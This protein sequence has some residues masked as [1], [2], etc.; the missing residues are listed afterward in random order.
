[1]AHKWTRWLHNPCRPGGPHR[2]KAGAESQ[3][4]TSGPGGYIT[5]AAWWVPTTSERGAQSDVANKWAGWLHNP[6]PLAGPQ[7]FRAGD[8]ISRGPQVPL[9]V[10]NMPT[11]STVAARVEQTKS[12]WGRQCL[13]TTNRN[14]RGRRVDGWGTRV[15]GVASADKTLSFCK[16]GA[17]GPTRLPLGPFRGVLWTPM[18]GGQTH[19]GGGVLSYTIYIYIYI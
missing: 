10:Y 16:L 13:R 15:N 6:C 19:G 7:R 3:L 11:V 18:G 4:P 17:F 8:R 5:P 1:M 9:R 2:F 12:S 14:F